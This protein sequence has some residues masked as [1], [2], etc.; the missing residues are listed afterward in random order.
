VAGNNVVT[1]IRCRR[2]VCQQLVHAGTAHF[3]L[4]HLRNLAAAVAITGAEALFTAVCENMT[5]V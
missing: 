3:L 1:F 5:A 4:L 2:R